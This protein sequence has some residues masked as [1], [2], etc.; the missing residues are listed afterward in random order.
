MADARAQAIFDKLGR[1]ALQEL[2][3]PEA[4]NAIGST[5]KTM[6]A[7]P[8]I[9]QALQAVMGG[10]VDAAGKAGVEVPPD[11]IEQ[12][13]IAIAGVLASMLSEAGLADNPDQ[14]MAEVAKL[15]GGGGGEDEAA[16]SPQQEA[17]E[18][19]P[20]GEPMDEPP[21]GALAQMRGG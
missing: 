14:V 12:A 15:M 13:Q 19:G 6:G 9:A 16:E 1:M 21:G 7:A 4:A 3:K 10:I 18:H 17:G 11:A 2:S 8:A 20:G 5:A